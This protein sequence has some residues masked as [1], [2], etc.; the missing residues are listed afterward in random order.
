M[1][2]FLAGLHWGLAGWFFLDPQNSDIYLFVAVAILGMV[3]ASLANL[4]ALPYL[5]LVF[6]VTVFVFVIA[7]MVSLNN[8]PVVVMSCLFIFGLW[9]LSKKLGKQ[10]LASI[11]KDFKNAELLRLVMTCVSHYMLK[12]CF[13]PPL[14]LI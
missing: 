5:W 1:A 10:I 11:T 8:W 4:S 13:Y 9:G 6:A 3:S 14:S 2:L 12:D 7:R